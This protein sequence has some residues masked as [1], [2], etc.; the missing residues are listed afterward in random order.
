MLPVGFLVLIGL[1]YGREVLEHERLMAL[2][3]VEWLGVGAVGL[4]GWVVVLRVI[5]VACTRRITANNA[6]NRDGI[7]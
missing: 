5:F 3:G 7:G 4:M 1:F 2:S 6:A